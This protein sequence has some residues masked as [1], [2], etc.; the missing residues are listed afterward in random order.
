MRRRKK[1]GIAAKQADGESF[2]PS[3]GEVGETKQG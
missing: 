1:R 2:D 3:L